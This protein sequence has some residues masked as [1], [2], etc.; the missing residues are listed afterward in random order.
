MGRS[1]EVACLGDADE[2]A[3]QALAHVAAMV[4]V[5]YKFHWDG[6]VVEKY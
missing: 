6:L 1:A 3:S 4:G 2:V 5:N